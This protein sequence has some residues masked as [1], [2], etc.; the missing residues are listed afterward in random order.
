M[1]VLDAATNAVIAG[2][3]REDSSPVSGSFQGAP[4]AWKNNAAMPAGKNIRL[5]FHLEGAGTRL[6]SF[7]FE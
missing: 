1:E 4:A 3:S 7:W 2:Y 6:Y 5:R